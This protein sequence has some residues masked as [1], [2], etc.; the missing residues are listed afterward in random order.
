MT[1]DATIVSQVGQCA[2]G[3]GLSTMT[4]TGTPAKMGPKTGCERLAWDRIRS[5]ADDNNYAVAFLML[6]DRFGLTDRCPSKTD[7]AT[8]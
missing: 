4:L 6:V 8:Q 1:N 7:G 2:G 3:H 5:Q